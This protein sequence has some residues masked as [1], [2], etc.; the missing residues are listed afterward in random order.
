DFLRRRAR[1]NASEFERAFF[2]GQYRSA[3]SS[4]SLGSFVEQVTGVAA[5][6]GGLATLAKEVEQLD[7]EFGHYERDIARNLRQTDRYSRSIAK[8][9]ELESDLEKLRA[10]L[11]KA[12]EE[13]DAGRR[14]IETRRAWIAGR[15]EIEKALQRLSS[16]SEKDIPA[17]VAGVLDLQASVPRDREGGGRLPREAVEHR[18]GIEEGLRK[19][20]QLF[21]DYDALARAWEEEKDEIETD[22]DPDAEGGLAARCGKERLRGAALRSAVCRCGWVLLLPAALVSLAG[23]A[24]LWAVCLWPAAEEWLASRSVERWAAAVGAGAVTA[25]ALVA[26][27]A[28][29]L[30]RRALER[31]LSLSVRSLQDLEAEVAGLE[32]QRGALEEI[33]RLREEGRIG[34]VIGAAEPAARG[35]ARDQLREFLQEHSELLASAGNGKSRGFRRLL[36]SLAKKEKQMREGLEAEIS[37]RQRELSEREAALKKSRSDRDRVENEIRDLRAQAAKNQALEEKNRELEGASASIRSEIDDRRLAAALLEETIGTVREKMGPTVSALIRAVLPHLTDA[38]Y[39]EVK[40]GKELEIHVFSREKSDFLPAQV[41]SGGTN[42]ALLLALRLAFSQAF[43]AARTSSSQFV[44]L[45]EPFQMMDVDRSISA[46]KALRRLSPQLSQFFAI[47]PRY[48]AS[49]RGSFD[50]LITTALAMT[51]LEVD[52]GLR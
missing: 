45:D 14:D 6:K 23:A 43:I 36:S 35:A 21:D 46:L 52:A 19:V 47:Q 51:T 18:R 16:A 39:R 11:A 50:C 29:W 10:E 4:I 17:G 2:H 49:Q 30:R 44:V 25:V 20:R 38:R 15:E 22:L 27:L 33:L 26:V 31:R 40:V 37:A 24:S 41:L 28:A 8:L 13:I 7:R 3:V 5:M 32:A 34:E 9:A 48:E 42:E 1:F 12:Q